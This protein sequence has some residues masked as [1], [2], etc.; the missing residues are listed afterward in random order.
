[1]SVCSWTLQFQ[2]TNV[3]KKEV[4]VRTLT[5][6]IQSMWNVKTKVIPVIVW[7]TGTVLKSLIIDCTRKA[8]Y[9]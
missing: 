9:Q 8:R 5:I 7:A 6:E 3:I 1:M 4:D 2:V